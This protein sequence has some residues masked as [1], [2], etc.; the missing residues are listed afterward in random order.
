VI[1]SVSCYI[2][3]RRVAATNQ[4]TSQPQNPSKAVGPERDRRAGQG[5]GERG[6][7]DDDRDLGR[8]APSAQRHVGRN[9]R[10]ASDLIKIAAT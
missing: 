7:G 8:S 10:R 1:T 2:A 5:L 3:P 6:G 4:A 9:G